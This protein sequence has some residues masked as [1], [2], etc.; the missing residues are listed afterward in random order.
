MSP[1]RARTRTRLVDAAQVVMGRVGV[2]AATIA[3]ITKEAGVGF[4][5]FYN[6]FRTKQE[7]AAEVFTRRSNELADEF[8]RLFVQVEDPVLAAALIQRSFIERARRD[9]IWGWFIIHADSVLP[10]VEKVFRDRIRKDLERS[11]DAGRFRIASLDMAVSITLAALLSTMRRQLKGEDLPS[12]TTD[13]IEAL[14]R[15]YGLAH[16]EARE[17]AAASKR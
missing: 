12:S 4:G 3:D 2:G 10:V 9:P 1:K 5:T 6:H 13:M 8:A 11:I 14:M 7:V 15:V 17:M 16:P